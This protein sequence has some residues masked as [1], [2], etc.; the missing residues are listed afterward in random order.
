MS[1]SS[2]A[3]SLGISTTWS[4][5]GC[6]SYV[7]LKIMRLF[8]RS[9]VDIWRSEKTIFWSGESF[10]FLIFIDDLLL[11][12]LVTIYNLLIRDK[13]IKL[14]V[15]SSFSFSSFPSSLF[16]FFFF[17]LFFFFFFF[18]SFYLF[19][20]KVKWI[21]QYKRVSYWH[22]NETFRQSA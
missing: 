4:F 11:S 18:E 5:N 15:S 2:F 8:L 22:N 17:R 20:V 14:F 13:Q 10:I 12:R 16:S 9:C 6:G 1:L 21:Y 3:I 7:I 19:F